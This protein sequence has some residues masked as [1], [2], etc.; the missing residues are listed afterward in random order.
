MCDKYKNIKRKIHKK[1][2]KVK[3]CLD[4]V[5]FETK[6]EAYQKNQSTYL[7]KY[8]GKW[9]RSGKMTEFI[10]ETVKYKI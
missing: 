9:H 3:S 2:R 8:C 6:Q 7:C 1:A 10:V 5:F 4:K